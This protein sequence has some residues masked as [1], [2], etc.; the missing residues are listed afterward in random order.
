MTV[1]EVSALGQ[2]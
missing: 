2:F 1:Y